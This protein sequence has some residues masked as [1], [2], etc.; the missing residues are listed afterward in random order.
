M[1]IRSFLPK[2][3][4]DA[5][6]GTLHASKKKENHLH[7]KKTL[8]MKKHILIILSILILIF[9]CQNESSNKQ[10][11]KEEIKNITNDSIPNQEEKSI[12]I[13]VLVEGLR[14]REHPT[15]N[16]KVID[17]LEENTELTYLDEKTDFTEEIT[18]RGVNYNQPW[19][20]VSF[21][22]KVGWVY[23]GGVS[24]IQNKQNKIEDSKFPNPN[25]KFKSSNEETQ[26]QAYVK[27]N[28]DQY[29]KKKLRNTNAEEAYMTS[30]ESKH[31]DLGIDII[32]EIYHMDE[33]TKVE[34]TNSSLE[35]VFSIMQKIYPN[36]D[37]FSLADNHKNFKEKK[38]YDG[39]V[40]RDEYTFEIIKANDGSPREI[41][42]KLSS[43]GPSITKITI[44]KIG[45][46]ISIVENYEST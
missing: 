8:K 29:S 30:Y 2:G 12:K 7:R 9:S 15:L 44:K 42:Y 36:L 38:V 32:K 35:E 14:L 26:F 16:A 37:R 40:F 33:S 10:I 34:I 19:F 46:K 25:R 23:G 5:Y 24:K 4:N 28:F 45:D 20:K 21:K 6:A 39:Q 41:R 31:S 27:D 1:H 18:L 13:N 3:R 11:V 22:D 17:G 43:I